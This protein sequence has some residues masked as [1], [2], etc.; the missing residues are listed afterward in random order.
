M[1]GIPKLLHYCFGFSEDFGGKPFGISHYVCIRSAI[2]RLHPARVRLY[3]EYEPESAWWRMLPEIVEKVRVVAPRAIF[4]NPIAHPAHRSDVARLRALIEHGGIY[5]D[6][7]VFVHGSFDHLLRNSV[8]LGREGDEA[9][10][11]LCNAVMLAEAQA[12]FLL[13]W[14]ETYRDFRGRGRGQNWNEHSV[15]RPAQLAAKFPNE[16]TILSNRAFF[17]P[18]FWPAD[19]A[20]I[21]DSDE[22]IVGPETLATHLWENKAWRRHLELMNPRSLRRS[23]SN[24][25]R[26]ATPYLA[27][28]PDDFTAP[29]P[30]SALRNLLGRMDD[31]RVECLFKVSNKFAKLRAKISA[32]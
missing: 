11:K 24:F 5:L 20:M 2:E 19:L 18:L 14:L 1:A 25:A 28:V 15:L 16:I 22:P 26:W 8:V 21:F 23:R 32:N 10:G 4:G 31:A 3:Y 9:D 17:W 27:G 30:A 29:G 7:D 13:K 12:P 6:A